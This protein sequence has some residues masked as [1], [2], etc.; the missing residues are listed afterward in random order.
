MEERKPVNEENSVISLKPSERNRENSNLC[1]EAR[2][3]RRKWLREMAMTLKLG[4]ILSILINVWLLISCQ[5]RILSVINGEEMK[6]FGPKWPW[7]WLSMQCGVAYKLNVIR[8][9]QRINE[10][11]GVINGVMAI[12][13]SHQCGQPSLIMKISSVMAAGEMASAAEMQY[14]RGT[15]KWPMAWR[16]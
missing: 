4:L 9:Y 12:S 16:S 15:A 11:N 2:P 13:A 3:Y 6:I 7:N 1:C 5:W 8:A 14:Q 10:N